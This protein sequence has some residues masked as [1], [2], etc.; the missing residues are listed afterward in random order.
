[1]A[2]PQLE[3]CVLGRSQLEERWHV[4]GLKLEGLKLEGLK[5]EGVQLEERR[6][7]GDRVT[8]PPRS[9]RQALVW[10]L[11]AVLA[12][13]GAALLRVAGFETSGTDWWL[14]VVLCLAFAGVESF[15]V[16][17]PMGRHTH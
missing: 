3:G 9:G 17:L 13:A 2:G 10:L 5:L 7:R 1:M 14:A 8:A 16:K 4:A 6:K 15:L 11:G 12:I